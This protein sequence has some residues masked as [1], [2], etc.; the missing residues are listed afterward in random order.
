M[1][2]GTR[3]DVSVTGTGPGATKREGREE[4]GVF[5][6]R[7]TPSTPVLDSTSGERHSVG[8]GAM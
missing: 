5:G 1:P 3:G 2:D 6:P 8:E 7:V 4:Q